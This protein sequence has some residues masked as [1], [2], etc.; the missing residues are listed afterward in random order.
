MPDVRCL[1]FPDVQPL[2]PR[3]MLHYHDYTLF[4]GLSRTDTEPDSLSHLLPADANTGTPETSDMLIGFTVATSSDTATP[5][6]PKHSSDDINS[7]EPDDQPHAPHSGPSYDFGSDPSFH[8]GHFQPF[9]KVDTGSEKPALMDPAHSSDS[10]NSN[11]QLDHPHA[12]YPGPSYDFGSDPS[13][14]PGHFQPFDDKP[15]YIG[16]QEP[17]MLHF[18]FI[19]LLEGGSYQSWQPASDLPGEQYPSSPQQEP[20]DNDADQETQDDTDSDPDT[21]YGALHP[22]YHSSAGC[23]DQETEEDVEQPGPGKS[24]GPES[25]TGS[26]SS[27]MLTLEDLAAIGESM[28]QHQHSGINWRP[29][30]HSHVSCHKDRH[31]GEVSHQH[32]GDDHSNSDVVTY[33]GVN[34]HD[35]HDTIAAW[36]QDDGSIGSINGH[37]DAEHSSDSDVTAFPDDSGDVSAHASQSDAAASASDGADS[38]SDTK[39]SSAVTFFSDSWGSSSHA[40]H[41]DEAPASNGADGGSNAN[42]SGTVASYSDGQGQGPSDH[43]SGHLLQDL[44]APH[45]HIGDGT[46]TSHLQQADSVSSAAAVYS[47]DDIQSLAL[48]LL[49]GDDVV[50]GGIVLKVPV[51]ADAPVREQGTLG[52][53]SDSQHQQ[54]DLLNQ[55]LG[56]HSSDS[57]PQLSH[58]DQQAGKVV[59]AAGAG[60]SVQEGKGQS[61]TGPHSEL[62]A[63]KEK[64]DGTGGCEP[65]AEQQ[66]P[67]LDAREQSDLPSARSAVTALPAASLAADS[68]TDSVSQSFDQ[69]GP[70]QQPN[71]DAAQQPGG[72]KLS[73]SGSTADVPSTK[74]LPALAS[75]ADSTRH[76]SAQGAPL[77]AQ[78]PSQQPDA[79]AQQVQQ[80]DIIKASDSGSTDSLPS[81]PAASGNTA[82]VSR[83]PSSLVGSELVASAPAGGRS[84]A[85]GADQGPVAAALLAQPQHLEHSGDAELAHSTELAVGQAPGAAAAAVAAPATT[86]AAIVTESL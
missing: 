6:N 26:D 82:A 46:S 51:H 45:S 24:E 40:N 7:N 66:Q 41:N 27:D 16:R 50:Q 85:D 57:E 52:P 10:I 28:H 18:H 61:G 14:H 19:D 56:G 48:D 81:P 38:S 83:Q 22:G 71:Q 70:L 72:N 34:P 49:A 43:R 44:L 80:L 32:Y 13:F 4:E 37:N 31:H 2:M 29:L 53:N 77:P 9:N 21:F 64:A 36:P 11:E 42:S 55:L 67:N 58:S 76:P 1:S 12:P 5:V 86:A 47:T 20:S 74:P 68:T 33:R 60:V 59:P 63:Y 3:K 84:M 15:G 23:D 35:T 79:A 78:Q 54:A 65:Q 69:Q 39:E 30:Q 75:T 25:L 62:Q 17:P 8:P 73:Q